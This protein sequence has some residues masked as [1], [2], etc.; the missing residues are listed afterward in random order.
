MELGSELVGLGRMSSALLLTGAPGTGK[1]SSLEALATL[2]E[3]EG[4]EFGA[5]EAEQL[6]WGE[7][8]LSF[9][10]AARQLAIVLQYQ[11]SAGR[12]L[13]LIAATAENSEEL[14]LITS[15][16]GAERLLVVCLSASPETV[17]SRLTVREPDSWPGKRDLIERARVL[18]LSMPGLARTDC[19]IETESADV[20]Q[21]AG[22]IHTE[23]RSHGLLSG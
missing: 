9:A 12:R 23:L 1:S 13:F 10:D 17:A 20:E 4:V 8:W 19:V 5:I 2:L 3:I 14:G 6:A 7:P 21:I 15:A 11:R 22:L 18:A 16:I